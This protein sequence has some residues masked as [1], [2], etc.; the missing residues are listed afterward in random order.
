[1]DPV[2][3]RV[4]KAWNIRARGIP[5]GETIENG[6]V[7]I[8][9]YADHFSITDLTNAGKRGK[10]VQKMNASPSYSYSGKPSDWMEGMS[11]ALTEFPSY[12]RVKSFFK[13]VLHDYPG[14]IDISET[15]LR[16]IDVTPA[17]FRTMEI[18]GKGVLVR[19][20]YKDFSVRNLDDE[21]NLTTCIPAI[22]GGLKDI[23]VFYRWVVENETKIREMDFP[24]VLKAMRSL[25]VKFHQY[26]AMD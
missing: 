10:R 8:H 14:E 15:Q 16:G 6:M 26:C 24:E 18:K 11:K 23:P 5:M 12:D 3:K 19:V 21:F 20:E 25:G 4:V 7:R 9:R 1:M 13:D 22:K 17:G 2:A